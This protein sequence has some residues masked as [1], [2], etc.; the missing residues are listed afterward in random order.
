MID[1]ETIIN[2]YKKQSNVKLYQNVKT[3]SLGKM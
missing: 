3:E 1:S 2:H